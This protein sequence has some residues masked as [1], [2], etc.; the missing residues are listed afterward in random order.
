MKL[1]LSPAKS[2]DFES[3]LPVNRYTTPDFLDTTEKINKKLSR[4]SKNELAELMNISPKLAELNYERYKEFEPEH[5][6]ENSRPAIFAFD[7][8]VYT[9][10][11]AY[12]IPVQKIDRL[13]DTVRILSGMYGI[14]K[15]LDLMQPYRLEMGT[16]IGINRKSNLYEVWQ[17][18]VTN[19]LNKEMEKDEFFVNLA[20]NEYFKAIDTKKLK[21]PVITPVF[22]D[23][24]N[25]KL[26]IISFFAK[27]ARG[28]MARFIIDKDINSI[29]GIKGFNYDGYRFSES[30]SKKENELI[31]TR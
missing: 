13:Q 28:S 7:G 20:S 3:E 11:D 19:A 18:K 24:K 4:L 9:G 31:F 15:P 5:T 10:L 1:I 22:K 30:E 2:L 25:G 8:D 21:A 16:S 17:Q 12:S 29:E 23:L 26:K 14:L 27:K 6:P